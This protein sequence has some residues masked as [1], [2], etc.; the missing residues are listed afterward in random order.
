MQNQKTF[1]YITWREPPQV[2]PPRWSCKIWRLKFVP[3][4][5]RYSNILSQSERSCPIRVGCAQ[6]SSEPSRNEDRWCGLPLI[7]RASTKS[8]LFFRSSKQ[9]FKRLA[10]NR[11]RLQKKRKCRWNEPAKLPWKFKKTKPPL[12]LWWNLFER[13]RSLARWLSTQWIVSKISQLMVISEYYLIIY[14]KHWYFLPISIAA[15]YRYFCRRN[16][17]CRCCWTGSQ[18]SLWYK[19]CYMYYSWCKWCSSTLLTKKFNGAELCASLC[20]NHLCDQLCQRMPRKI[21][22]QS[23]ACWY[24]CEENG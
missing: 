16:A 22:S 1:K 17:W 19:N 18:H 24:N 12:I 8:N 11:P 4:H 15:F 20:H 3:C 13:N 2:R 14:L 5:R 23:R 7:F 10:P 21:C 6:T 9:S